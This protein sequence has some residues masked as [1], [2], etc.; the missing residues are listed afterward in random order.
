MKRRYT[1]VNFWVHHAF[2]CTTMR[3][4]SIKKRVGRG[5]PFYCIVDNNVYNLYISI[6]KFHLKCYIEKN[7]KFLVICTDNCRTLLLKIQTHKNY[8]SHD[9]NA[10][11]NKLT[12]VEWVYLRVKTRINLKRCETFSMQIVQLMYNI[13]SWIYF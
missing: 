7:W 9:N 11:S 4:Q 10:L 8:F 13:M 1:A 12:H 2:T 6:F 3:I 5:G